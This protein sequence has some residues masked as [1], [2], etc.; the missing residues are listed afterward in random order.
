MTII[1][2][3]VSAKRRRRC[4]RRRPARPDRT[5][6]QPGEHAFTTRQTRKARTKDQGRVIALRQG[7]RRDDHRRRQ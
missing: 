5:E 1:A 4:R 2:G 7:D 3:M 6:Q